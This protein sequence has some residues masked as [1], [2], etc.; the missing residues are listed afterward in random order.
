MIKLLGTAMLTIFCLGL[1]TP[2]TADDLTAAS[3]WAAG[4]VRVDGA[5]DEWAGD[6]ATVH[7]KTKAT[8][9][10]RNDGDYLYLLLTFP[11]PG[12]LSTLDRSGV[13]VYFDGRGE[14]K[15]D[16]GL[17]FTKVMLT[18]DQ[19][20]ARR[21]SQGKEL[22]DAQLA[23]IRSKPFH[24]MFMFG[25]INKK[26]H[27]LMAHARPALSPDF[28]AAQE[29]EARVYEI[30]IPLVRDENQPFGIGADPGGAL[31]VGVEWG[32]RTEAPSQQEADFTR[33]ISDRDA[34]GVE[35]QI[36]KGTPK[37]TFWVAV[38]LAPRPL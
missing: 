10:A 3:A 15:K 22:T 25:I 7:P 19:L 36:R 21:R 8:F 1:S 13:T 20:I 35:T 38:T 27:A 23:E 37:Y 9:A 32:G 24:P 31:M 33:R 18:P 16:R 17:K 2:A 4:A 14:K 26:D 5:S 6:A 11:D 34:P 12:F 30:K 29:G 28:N